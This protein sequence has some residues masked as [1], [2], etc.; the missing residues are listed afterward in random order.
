MF[1][2]IVIRKIS[3]LLFDSVTMRYLIP[4][5]YDI[6][7]YHCRQ[8]NSSSMTYRLISKSNF[9]CLIGLDLDAKFLF[10]SVYDMYMIAM[11]SLI[12]EA[13]TKI[14]G[15]QRLVILPNQIFSI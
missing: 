7:C 13:E 5:S 10:I 11:I 8:K 9:C 14:E 12:V 1:G 4:E 2:K 6:C 15:T 3:F